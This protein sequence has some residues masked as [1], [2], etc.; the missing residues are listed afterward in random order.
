MK[1]D[2]INPLLRVIELSSYRVI[3]VALSGGSDSMALALMAAEAGLKFT[4]VTVDHGLRPESAAETAQVGEWMAA[5][6]IQHRILRW[7]HN[8][9][10]KGNLQQAARFA[11]Y[12]L[13]TEY[14]GTDG[15]LLVAH[16]EDDQAETI[17]LR[18]ARNS[19]PVG[20]AGMKARTQW[21]GVEILRP[22]LDFRREELRDYLRAQG[23]E[24]IDDPSNENLK[25]DR[26]RI[27]KE[28][29]ADPERRA[30]LLALGREMA[31]ERERLER[32]FAAFV[33]K[34][35]PSGLTRGSRAV[36]PDA[37]VEPEQGM[38]VGRDTF[39]SLS[40]ET[41]IYALSRMLRSVSGR[42]HP[43]RY[44]ELERLYAT[45]R[46]NPKGKATLG[47]CFIAWDTTSMRLTSEPA[48]ACANKLP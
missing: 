28:L 23:Q 40:P 34:L 4:A 17:A 11:R 30:A 1:R 25:F 38:S 18:Q 7:E 20:L 10:I 36:P 29:A 12:D 32:E 33:S 47:K 43:P 19:G 3:V 48:A 24:W 31:V 2:L 45:I 35:P 9:A 6:G 44:R 37:R 27:R 22:L 5:C 42:H 39:L 13:L 41:A 26:I 16:T 8:G 15:L 14:C 21:S 46:D